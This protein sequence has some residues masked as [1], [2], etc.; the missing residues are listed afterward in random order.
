MNVSNQL[1]AHARYESNRS[2]LALMCACVVLLTA[3]ICKQ[4]PAQAA[5]AS[6]K[7]SLADLDL[8]TDKGMQ[9]ARDRLHKTARRLCARIIDPWGLAPHADLVRCVDDATADA[10]G[11][12][13]GLTLVA[14]AAH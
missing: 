4:L 5:D 1:P 2:K 3:A 6:V 8:S 9:T 7:V 12:I 13:Q 14:N 11:R 10:V